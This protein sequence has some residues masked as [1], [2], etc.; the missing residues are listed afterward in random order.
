MR[1]KFTQITNISVCPFKLFSLVKS[2]QGEKMVFIKGNELRLTQVEFFFLKSVDSCFLKT[3]F[4]Q[5]F[6]ST[7]FSISNYFQ[8]FSSYLLLKTSFLLYI[9]G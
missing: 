9:T 2:T 8:T 1:F 7:N 5:I 6:F 3:Y 4:L